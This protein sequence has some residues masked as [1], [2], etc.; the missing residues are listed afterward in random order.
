[1]KHANEKVGKHRISRRSWQRLA[2]RGLC[3]S[4]CGGEGGVWV[5]RVLCP[6]CRARCQGAGGS[7][8]EL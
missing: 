6:A 2:D 4:R 3:C 8:G 7:G 1:M 5:P